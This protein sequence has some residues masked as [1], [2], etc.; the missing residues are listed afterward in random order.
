MQACSQMQACPTACPHAR[1][2]SPR[3]VGALAAGLLDAGAA[4]AAAAP[5]AGWGVKNAAECRID[6][7]SPSCGSAGVQPM[8]AQRQGAGA[9]QAGAGGAQPRRQGA[10]MWAGGR[11]EKAPGALAIAH[12]P[13]RTVQTPVGRQDARVRSRGSREGSACRLPH[14]GAAAR[15]SPSS[16]GH[17]ARPAPHLLELGNLIL[18]Q[19]VLGSHGIATSSFLGSHSSRVLPACVGCAER[20]CAGCWAAGRGLCWLGGKFLHTCYHT[21]SM[22]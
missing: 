2:R 22:L 11:R 3:A 9:G 20:G 19:L 7:P 8:S 18:G 14:G 1:P 17:A 21:L 6:P 4:C 12:E 16:L 13:Y 10:C 15:P 5:H